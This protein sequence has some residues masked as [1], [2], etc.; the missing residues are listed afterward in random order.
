MSGLPW[1][2]LLVLTPLLGG[3]VVMGLDRSRSELARGL[4]LAVSGLSALLVLVVTANFDAAQGG[5]QLVEKH[6]WVP[7]LGV[8]YY[9]GVDGLGLAMVWL[10]ALLVPMALW[11]A[12][13]VEDRVPLFQGLVLLLQAGLFGTFTALNF[14]HWFLF[15][16][17]SLVPAFFLIKF[18]GGAERSKAATQ[19]FVYTM[20][21]SVTML[22]A[23][24]ALFLA[25]G[26]MDLVGL[27]GL[28]SEGRLEE[29][30]GAKLAWGG[31]SS[32]GMM[33]LLFLGTLLAVA[34]KVPMMPFHTWLPS[35]YCEAPT[36]VTM[37][38]TG[39]MSKMGVY[40]LLRLVLPIYPE[41]MREWQLPL[42]VLALLTV[43]GGSVLAMVQKDLKRLL[44]YSSVNHL[45]Y[46]LLAVFCV[47]GAVSGEQGVEG[48]TAALSGVVLQMFNHG[49]T[50]A[51]LFAFVAF[52]ERRG[53]V[54]EMLQVGGLRAVA[55]VFTGL[56]GVALFSSLG[57]PGL[58]G[59]VGEFLIF[60]GVV[61]LA[62]WAA[63][64][65]APA[66]LFTAVFI[67]SWIQRVFLGP[68]RLPAGGFEGLTLREFVAVGPAVGLMFLLG[69]WPQAL[70]G[71]FN[72]T[73]V[74]WVKQWPW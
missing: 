43:V 10:A 34:V 31:L 61:G 1:L 38:L 70:V 23:F 37:L 69:I 44:A 48:R 25:T 64:V 53:L 21:G 56:M 29:L 18:W 57:L 74:V 59:F 15:W 8:D 42:M 62:G 68:V 11:V 36:S 7:A 24:V 27:A 54:G 14:F 40:A 35:T 17:L 22:L 26:T 73:V 19:F 67:L 13:P 3:F 47:A 28:A 51:T 65:A 9:L 72:E 49:L 5:I 30:V 4:A 41:A 66:L 33:Q 63:L 50:A 60:K 71:W 55:P 39:V 20:G 16:E 52:L 46:C 58:N 2:T 32:G 45:G 6:V 12:R